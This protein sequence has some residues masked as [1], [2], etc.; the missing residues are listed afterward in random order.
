MDISPTFNIVDL[1]KYHELDVEVVVLDDYPKK[2]VEEVEHILDQKFS[3]RTRE[4][5]YYEYLVKWKK[6]LVEDATWI[7]QSKLDST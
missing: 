2:W 6:K 3:K 4:K 1:H 5:D 7:Y